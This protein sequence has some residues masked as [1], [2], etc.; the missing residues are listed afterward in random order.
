MAPPSPDLQ[1][2]PQGDFG[3]VWA[4]FDGPRVS[5]QCGRPPG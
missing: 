3:L 1:R 5:R 2:F 4:D